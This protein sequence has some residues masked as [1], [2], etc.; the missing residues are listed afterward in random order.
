MLGG[1]AATWNGLLSRR[2][3]TR[4]PPTVGVDTEPSRGQVGCAS[5]SAESVRR[6]TC[7][8]WLEHHTPQEH[9]ALLLRWIQENVDLTRGMLF[10]E[11]VQEFYAEAVI[12][13]GW[14]PRPWNPVAHELD[15]L[16][17]GGAKPYV[18]VMA[19]TGRMHRRRHYPIPACEIDICA[20][21]R[22]AA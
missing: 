3:R 18:W 8:D 2:D 16:C 20:I 1:I 19:P 12:G 21:R 13:A 4:A 15:L 17:T 6:R 22:R 5:L 11:A 14:N 10:R 7:D 9:A